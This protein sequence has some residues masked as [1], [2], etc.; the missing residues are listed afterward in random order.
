M[1]NQRGRKLSSK[2]Q[3]SAEYLLTL[4]AVFIVFAGVPFLFTNQVNRYLSFLF[5]LITL[6]F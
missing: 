4:A 5:D 6:P 1:F 3:A 2:G